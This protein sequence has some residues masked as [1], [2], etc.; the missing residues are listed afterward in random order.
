MDSFDL[1]KETD[2]AVGRICIAIGKGNM[3]DEV[4]R[5]ITYHRRMAFDAGVEAS[6]DKT[7]NALLARPRRG[8]L[9]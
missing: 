2:E 6:K 3:R 9:K 5:L 7:R 4:I 1:T 8:T